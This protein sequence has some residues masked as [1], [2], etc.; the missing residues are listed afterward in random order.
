MTLPQPRPSLPL[1]IKSPLLGSVT[2]FEDSCRSVGD[3]YKC[4]L[5]TEMYLKQNVN[6]ILTLFAFKFEMAM[7]FGDC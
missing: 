6:L 5:I 3:A 1:H 2:V 7:S 4:A